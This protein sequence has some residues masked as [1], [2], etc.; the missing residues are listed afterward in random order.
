MMVVVSD[1]VISDSY[2]PTDCSRPGSSVLARV[3]E[4]VA[5]SSS[6]ESSRPRD[7]THLSCISC[8][9]RWILSSEPPEKTKYMMCL[10]AKSLQPCPVLCNRMDHN[11]SGSS[12]REILQEWILGW[13]AMP[14]SRKSS[15][16]RD[17]TH[18]SCI[19][20]IGRWT[21]YHQHQPESPKYIT[22]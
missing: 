20:C 14:S 2:N 8:I 13:V 11:P 6:R 5:I 22:A 9:R 4:W 10:S 18:V 17:W 19:S 1:W 12:V 16:S 21:L 7:W 15:W 3:L